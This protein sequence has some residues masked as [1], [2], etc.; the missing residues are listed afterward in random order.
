MEILLFIALLQVKNK[1]IEVNKSII[2]ICN[3]ILKNNFCF[4]FSSKGCAKFNHD[5]GPKTNRIVFD[6]NDAS[7][8]KE[9]GR[10]CQ[11]EEK[12]TKWTYF[13]LGNTCYMYSEC[14]YESSGLENKYV[15]GEKSCPSSEG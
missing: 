7:S 2:E 13:G 9:C 12:C 4:I 6:G 14:D 11:R 8:W 15:A 1:T 10:M 5:C 3:S